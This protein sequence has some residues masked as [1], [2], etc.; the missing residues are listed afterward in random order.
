MLVFPT[1]LFPPRDNVALY[2]AGQRRSPGRTAGG[3][4]PTVV[5]GGTGWWCYDQAIFLHELAAQQTWQALEAITDSGAT[6]MV[7]PLSW[8]VD[9]FAPLAPGVSQPAAVPFSDGAYFDDS[10]GFDGGAITAKLSVGANMNAVEV[11]ITMTGG[12]RALVGNEH[13]TID[14]TIVGPRAYRIGQIKAVVGD[15]YTV[16]IRPWL[17]QSVVAETELDFNNPRMVANIPDPMTFR[18][19]LDINRHS[20]V[21][22]RFE[23]YFDEYDF[24]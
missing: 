16:A 9:Q 4:N 15:V 11:Q 3:Q 14:H 19:P 13:F 17:R 21:E 5:S 8:A 10:T 20:S 12:H 22:L 2:L 18:M 24:G 1:A 6:A 23:E 7:V